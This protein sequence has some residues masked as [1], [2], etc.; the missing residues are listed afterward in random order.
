VGYRLVFV[1]I[2]LKRPLVTVGITSYN[3]ASTIARC[4]QS[5]VNQSLNATRIEVVIVDDGSTDD[6]LVQARQFRAAAPWAR[7]RVLRQRNTGNASVGRNRILDTAMGRYLFYVDAD[8]YLGPEALEATTESA[9]RHRADVV[10]GRYVGVNRSAPNVLGADELPE[11]HD[12][13]AGWLNSLHIQKLFRTDFLR[14]LS[15][16]FNPQLFYANDHPFMVS[17]FLDAKRVSFVN[18]VDC[19]FITLL[20][21]GTGSGHVSRAELSA[22]EQLRFL[23]DCFGVLALA[24]GRGGAYASLAGRMRADYWNRLLKLHLPT[25][26]VRKD[27][28]CAVM[29]L[30]RA[31]SNLAEIYGAKTSRARLTSASDQM[32]EALRTADEKVL[33]E[34]ARTVRQRPN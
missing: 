34:T 31:A 8:D 20:E 21:H 11:V 2:T 18:D 25:L 12:Y 22:T 5:M 3:N 15:Y 23:H 29:E 26:L 13:H 27:D 7:F 16:R 32:L 9:R 10:V 4:L 6:T 30:A 33:S 1:R 17:A 19:Y 24:R 14:G 28:P